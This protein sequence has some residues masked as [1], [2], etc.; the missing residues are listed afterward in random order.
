MCPLFGEKDEV[1]LG[2]WLKQEI[3]V[4]LTFLRSDSSRECERSGGVIQFTSSFVS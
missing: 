1:Y 4:L 2:I 3:F